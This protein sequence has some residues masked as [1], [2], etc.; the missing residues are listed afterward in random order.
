MQTKLLS[1]LTIS[2][3]PLIAGAWGLPKIKNPVTAVTESIT[4]DSKTDDAATPEPLFSGDYIETIKDIEKQLKKGAKGKDALLL[5]LEKGAIYR[6]AALAG[7]DL[8]RKL[9]SENKEDLPPREFLLQESTAAFD[10]ADAM[11]NAFDEKA[12]LRVSQEAVAMLTNQASRDYTGR[13]YDKILVNAFKAKN[14]MAAGAFDSARVELNRCLQRQRDIV[15]L[16]AKAIEDAMNE[17]AAAETDKETADKVDRAR[18]DPTTSAALEEIEAEVD[19]RIR[20]YGDFVNPYTVFLDGLFFLFKAQDAGD[21]ERARKS[22]ERVV[23]MVPKNPYVRDDLKAA[24][25]ASAPDNITYVLIETGRAPLRAEKK[26][27][28]PTFLLTSEISYIGA[29]FPKLVYFDDYESVF[30]VHSDAG[31]LPS[32]T[33]SSM[34]SVVSQDFK[35]DWSQVVSRTI[36]STVTKAGADVA[37]QNA[38][39]NSFGF[40]GQLL[41]KAVSAGV[42]SKMNQADTRTWTSLPKEFQYIRV[43]TP[44]SGELTIVDSNGSSQT[45]R[46]EP[47]AVNVVQLRSESKGAPMEISQFT[48]SSKI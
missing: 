3:V 23:G 44:A 5:Y 19:S 47:G 34:D 32:A 15:A 2:L 22:F 39:S 21:L 16:N 25:N 14:Y 37:V 24:E 7:I 18:T 26:I 12:K 6:S 42:Q 20:A 41:T 46:V 33:L 30:T 35:S 10:Q 40:T 48:F 28:I 27:E 38:A 13:S 1:C 29:A 36:R 17:E 11:I 43:E 45:V 9:A 8:P 4:S 31:S